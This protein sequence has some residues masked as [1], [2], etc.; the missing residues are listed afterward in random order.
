MTSLLPALL[1]ITAMLVDSAWMTGQPALWK[2][3]GTDPAANRLPT[4]LTYSCD[5]PLR[6]AL[7]GLAPSLCHSEPTGVRG[8]VVCTRCL[9]DIGWV[10][11]DGR[12]S[13]AVVATD[14]PETACATSANNR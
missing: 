7:T 4:D 8:Y 12:A 10:A 5:L 13:E 3:M 14:F 9:R 6:N 11:G 1:Q 2:A